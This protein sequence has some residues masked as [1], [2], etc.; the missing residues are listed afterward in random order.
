MK[1]S[2][3]LIRKSSA[4]GWKKYIIFSFVIS[5]VIAGCSVGD[6]HKVLTLI[7]DGVPE[8]IDY[9]LL[10]YN[11]SVA[12]GNALADSIYQANLPPEEKI[13]NEN[14]IHPPFLLRACDKCHKSKGGGQFQKP[15]PDLCYQCH[16]NFNEK[17]ANLHAPVGGGFCTEC[18]HPHESKNSKLLRKKDRALCFKCHNEARVLA[19]SFHTKIGNK[20]C[21]IC[22]DPH[23]S[24][25]AGNSFSLKREACT[26]CHQGL[27]K[28]YSYVH[29]PVNA[30]ECAI[31][32]GSHTLTTPKKLLRKGAETCFYCHTPSLILKNKVHLINKQFDCTKCHNPHAAENRL[33]LKDNS[34]GKLEHIEKSKRIIKEIFNDIE[35][36]EI[37]YANRIEKRKREQLNVIIHT[38]KE[39]KVKVYKLAENILIAKIKNEPIIV[40]ETKIKAEKLAIEVAHLKTKYTKL[41]EEIMATLLPLQ[42]DSTINVQAKNFSNTKDSLKNTTTLIINENGLIDHSNDS[43]ATGMIMKDDSVTTGMLMNKEKILQSTNKTSNLINDSTATGMLMKNDS[44][45]TGM[46]L[47][48][49]STFK[50]TASIIENRDSLY[51]KESLDSELEI[52]KEKLNTVLNE[53]NYFESKML[54]I[55]TYKVQGLM[56]KDDLINEK[57]LLIQNKK[58][59][60]DSISKQINKIQYAHYNTK[61]KIALISSLKYKMGSIKQAIKLELADLINTIKAAVVVHEDSIQKYIKANTLKLKVEFG[62]AYVYPEFFD[63]GSAALNPKAFPVLNKLA[64]ILISLPNPRVEMT[65]HA[66]AFRDV[67][68]MKKIFTA[69]GIEYS[70]AE[71]EERSTR[72]NQQLSQK[73]VQTIVAY[74]VSKGVSRSW[75]KVEGLGESKPITLNFYPDATDNTKGRILNRRIEFKILSLNTN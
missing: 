8:L 40:A 19:V 75:L 30:G 28:S 1:K 29:A 48:G 42:N 55:N 58:I 16:Q 2:K 69:N 74:L 45:A 37:N 64:T 33:L 18:H 65:A 6:R 60:L 47:Q 20:N 66:D 71:H 9:E 10:A 26:S 36:M 46:L 50:E 22:H 51:G 38:A 11:D 21:T 72:Y 15:Q 70:T 39:N 31:C 32:H 53:L 73:R 3:S 56:L 61:E 34:T 12:V 52:S 4:I 67:A 44:V 68:K 13:K 7:F 62:K 25:N 17:Y 41:K 57:Q 54:A 49:D 5:I 59:A 43:V 27:L 63:F 35:K 14:S 24:K 23:G